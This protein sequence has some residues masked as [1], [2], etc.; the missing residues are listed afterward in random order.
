MPHTDIT[1]CS[2]ETLMLA[3]RDTLDETFFTE[4]MGRHYGA[5]LHIAE[6]RLFDSENAA[7]AVQE[8]FVRVVRKRKHYDG[9]RFAPWFYTILR[10]ICTDI[11]RREMRRRNK[12]EAFRAE[13][14]EAAPAMRHD[15]FDALVASLPPRDRETLT[16]RY[17]AGL[18][19]S[20]IAPLLDCTEDAA[21]KR[22]Q[23][24]L[25]RLREQFV[26]ENGDET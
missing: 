19:F 24:A 5:A 22:V 21:K 26:P 10:N 4:L 14:P 2:D 6:T 15:E 13:A 12:M 9:R 17:A 8:A 23:R 18:S 20:E 1:H 25:A 3:F 11:I 16:L 7:D